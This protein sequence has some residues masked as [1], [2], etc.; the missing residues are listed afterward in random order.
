[1]PYRIAGIDVHK[2]I[3]AVVVADV[4]SQGEYQFERRRFGCGRDQMRE[5]VEWLIQHQTQEVVMEST[6][7]Y[8]RPVWETLERYW[9]SACEKEAGQGTRSG[10]LHLAQGRSNRGP[11]GRKNDF[12]DG[13]RLVKRLVAGELILSF[14][15]DPDQR[16][17]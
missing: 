11:R 2:K 14:V 16:L 13:E 4:A 15:P 9:K 3:L 7:Q 6:A 5:M 12:A 10:A 1:M 8:W 17:W